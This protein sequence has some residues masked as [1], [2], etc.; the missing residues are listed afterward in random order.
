VFAE[1]FIGKADLHAQAN[2]HTPS[3][4]VLRLRAGR[5][6]LTDVFEFHTQPVPQRALSTQL[7]KQRFGTL[8]RLWRWH[9]LAFKE[10]PEASLDFSFSKQSKPPQVKRRR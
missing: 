1:R 4:R 10:V 2:W 3:V 6:Q 5:V 7:V 8:E 9:F